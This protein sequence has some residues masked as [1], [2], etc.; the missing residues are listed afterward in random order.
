MIDAIIEEKVRS[1]FYG[2]PVEIFTKDKC[3]LE[4]GDIFVREYPDSMVYYAE[5][6]GRRNAIIQIGRAHV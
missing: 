6:T 1:I 2:N 3:K 5:I 4:I